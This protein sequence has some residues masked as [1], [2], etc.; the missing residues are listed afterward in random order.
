MKDK[1]LFSRG[2]EAIFPKASEEGA[3]QWR[4]AFLDGLYSNREAMNKLVKEQL[5]DMWPESHKGVGHKHGYRTRSLTSGSEA[6]SALNK[7]FSKK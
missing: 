2:P 3:I 1:T 7:V 5:S 6:S 4:Q